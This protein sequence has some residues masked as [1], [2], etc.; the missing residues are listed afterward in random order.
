MDLYA[1]RNCK[2]DLFYCAIFITTV[3]RTYMHLE[4]ATQVVYAMVPF[5]FNGDSL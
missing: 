5:F 4:V 3:Q 1:L 2:S